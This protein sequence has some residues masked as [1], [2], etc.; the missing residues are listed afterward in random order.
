M[1]A[2][3][4]YR[5]RVITMPSRR[6]LIL[7]CSAATVGSAPAW[8][9]A[10]APAAIVPAFLLV[11]VL[12][13]WIAAGRLW[14]H[15]GVL[16][17]AAAAFGLSFVACLL[18]SVVV[19]ELHVP[20][21]AAAWVWCALTAAGLWLLKPGVEFP[22]SRPERIMATMSLLLLAVIAVAGWHIGGT[23]GNLAG[24]E[25]YHVIFTR[26]LHAHP[27]PSA[28]NLFYLPGTSSTY[29]YMPYHASLA[30]MATLGGLDPM[31]VFVK[32]RPFAAIV[33]L[34][35]MA[36]LAQRMT[37]RGF[38][39]WTTLLV[40]GVGVLTNH[41]GYH[42]PYFAQLMPVSHHSD[43]SLGMGLAVGGYFFWSAATAAVRFRG[44]F[45]CGAAVMIAVL[46]CHAREG[47]QLVVLC[48]VLCATGLCFRFRDRTLMLHTAALAILLIVAGKGYQGLQAVRAPH[49]A[50]WEEAEKSVARERFEA[51]KSDVRAG[52][53]HALFGPR[54]DRTTA[55]MPNYN[56]FFRPAYALALLAVP[57]TFWG[58][59][60]LWSSFVPVLVGAIL[61]LSRLPVTALLL[62]T[63]GYSQILYTPARF[64][65]H[66]EWLLLAIGAATIAEFAGRR[67]D[68][69]ASSVR[70]RLATVLAINA[71][72][73]LG[74][75][76]LPALGEALQ[77][78]S[79]RHPDL[80][81]IGVLLA[82]EAGTVWRLR[83]WSMGTASDVEAAAHAPAW[84]S[85]AL[86]G[87]L[88]VP[89]ATWTSPPS[90]ADQAETAAARP[91]GLDVDAWCAETGLLDVPPETSAY[92]RDVLPRGRVLACD[93]RYIFNYP[94]VFDHY[95][96]TFGFYFS[97]E[98]PFL[99][100][101]YAIR[102]RTPPF[103][104]SIRTMYR[105]TDVYIRDLM[106]RFPL[107]NWIDPLDVTL[108][109]IEENGIEVIVVD[110][111]FASLWDTYAAYFPRAFRRLHAHGDHSV[112]GV[113]RDALRDARAAVAADSAGWTRRDLESGYSAR[114]LAGLDRLAPADRAAIWSD[115]R[116][117]LPGTPS[118]ADTFSRMTC[119]V[120][121]Q[122]HYDTHVDGR[123]WR[124][125]D[126]LPAARVQ[127]RDDRVDVLIGPLQPELSMPVFL[128][129]PRPYFVLLECDGDVV[130]D[131]A[132]PVRR[133][134][135][136]VDGPGFREL[137]L[138]FRGTAESAVS[139]R[140]VED[141]TAAA[142]RVV[143]PV[144][145]D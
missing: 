4:R 121:A 99:E 11:Y 51:L 37:G 92:L 110:P 32:F 123:A 97:S 66:W 86:A 137:R 44:V 20:M 17:R 56:I 26:K 134:V 2:E 12:P 47:L 115:L 16:E 6:H 62:V 69:L 111:E 7:G 60:S 33:T 142:V 67:L 89:L 138:S 22:A 48:G 107:F 124:T 64:V 139:V 127:Q 25:G 113:E 42:S 114:V 82:L 125:P 74:F 88:I 50:G 103:D 81:P 120:P 143:L 55:Y 41:A 83:R 95:I 13:G 61:L 75:W 116:T 57:L 140:I 29:L 36:A 38:V 10:L 72:F 98:T 85:V 52:R 43:V 119:F 80:I 58:G 34:V 63:G 90:L 21:R 53:W 133:N 106:L 104:P 91:N 18:L 24:E 31:S 100:R 105:F 76:G 28:D 109:E 122:R 96:F 132:E 45:W 129:K 73:A 144:V 128:P 102:G 65:L 59:R 54:I 23:Y 49:L 118:D 145:R 5:L 94:V 70:R 35:S 108:R 101:Y 126:G 30:L 141:E 9:P 19:V 3:R 87:A 93:P 78:A 112:Y 79:E 15:R 117:T 1:A 68:A 14:P 8:M 135:F 131:P 84:R 40:L 46:I 77:S 71:A 27:S 136:R 130:V 39:G